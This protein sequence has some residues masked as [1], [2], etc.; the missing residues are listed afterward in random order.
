[1]NLILKAVTLIF[2]ILVLM[3]WMQGWEGT[4]GWLPAFGLIVF[5][6]HVAEA[7]FFWARFREKSTNLPVDMVQVLLFGIIHWKKYLTAR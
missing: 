3:A 5:V 6:A 7:A 2:W 4:L 1:M